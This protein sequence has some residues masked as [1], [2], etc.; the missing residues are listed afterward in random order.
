MTKKFYSTS[1]VAHILR[2]SR[3]SVFNRIKTGKI[4]AEKV[5][6][7]YIITHESLLEALGE[8]IGKEKKESIEKAVS[9]AVKEYEEVFKKLGKE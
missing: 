9:K 2:I 7:T 1:D 3:I 6:K 5:G 8:S 4:R